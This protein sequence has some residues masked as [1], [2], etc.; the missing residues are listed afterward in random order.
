MVAQEI[1]A[2]GVS[3]PAVLK[4]MRTTP[5]HEFVPA[6]FRHLAYFD[7]ALPIGDQQTISPPFVV[8]YMT[9]ELDPKPSARNRHRQRLPGGGS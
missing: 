3:H 6:G 4:S 8:A 2:A 9:Q 1:E 5:R 7:A